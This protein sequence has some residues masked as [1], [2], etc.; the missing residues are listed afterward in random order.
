MAGTVT[1][2]EITFKPT[3]KIKW[4]W[5]SDGSGNA[6]QI[7]TESYYG[8]VLALVTIPSGGGTAPTDNYDITITD[9][10]GYDVMQAAGANRDTANTETAVPGSTSVAHGQLTLNV[11]NAGAS[12]QGSAI[13]YIKE[14]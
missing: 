12:K 1:L 10:E 8:E 13:L 5:T 9:S 7:T 4:E 14:R 6:D 3:K 2:T 11:S